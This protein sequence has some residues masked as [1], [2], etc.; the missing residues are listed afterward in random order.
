LA[1]TFLLVVVF[2]AAVFFFGFFFATAIACS[3]GNSV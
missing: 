3:F 1:V 2:L